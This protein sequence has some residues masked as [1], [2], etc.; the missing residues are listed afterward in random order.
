MGEGVY[1]GCLWA[2]LEAK[3]GGEEGLA[4]YKGMWHMCRGKL[5]DSGNVSH[6]G[7]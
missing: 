7:S 1:R 3:R 2:R 5:Y 4:F 6:F